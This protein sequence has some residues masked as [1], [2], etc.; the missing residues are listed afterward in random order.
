MNLI[1]VN[2]QLKVFL[3]VLNQIF[4]IEKKAERIEERNSIHRN[5]RR[6]KEIFEEDLPIF[7]SGGGLIVE[8]PIGEKYDETRGDCEASISGEGTENLVIEEVI[9]PIIYFHQDGFRQIVQKGVVIV[10]SKEKD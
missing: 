1:T 5:V 3:D 2:P 7:K 10:K 9:K 8:N 6:L 4:D